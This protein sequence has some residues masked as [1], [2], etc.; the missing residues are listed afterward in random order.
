MRI[1]STAA[2]WNSLAVLFRDYVAALP[3]ELDFQ[4]FDAELADLPAEYGP[5]HG[6]A[7]ISSYRDTDVGAVGVRRL[8]TGIAEL[9]R[10]YVRDAGRGQGIGRALA[11]EALTCAKNLGYANVVLDTVASLTA[12]NN[13]YESLGFREISPYRH[14][15]RPDARYLGLE[16]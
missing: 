14:N 8:E 9:K 1:A 13:L 16:L 15:P 7:L 6:V 5:P 11:V 2:D 10:M 4:D 12:A 3:F